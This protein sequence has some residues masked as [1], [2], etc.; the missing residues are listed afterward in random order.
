MELRIR[1]YDEVSSERVSV[2]V[3]PGQ[4]LEIEL[5]AP[6]EGNQHALYNAALDADRK[7]TQ[8][9]RELKEAENETAM[10]AQL[11]ALAQRRIAVLETKMEDRYTT[12]ELDVATRTAAD[13]A[14]ASAHAEI[15]R[16]E[17]ELEQSRIY[18][19]AQHEIVKQTEDDANAERDRANAERDRADRLATELDR[20]RRA[21]VCTT[22]CKPN[23]HTAFVGRRLVAEL[24]AMLAESRELVNAK[25]GVIEGLQDRFATL[26]GGVGRFTVAQLNEATR[27]AADQATA[28]ARAEIEELER[29]VK[30]YDMDRHAERDRADRNGAHSSKLAEELE[31][32][33]RQSEA[34]IAARDRL[35]SNA[36][37]KI[38]TAQEI[39]R[40]PKIS[41]TCEEIITAKGATLADAI[42]DAL[43]ALD[44]AINILA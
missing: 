7:L 42:R 8:V 39:L 40:A 19:R 1:T 4:R 27:T 32:L 2:E 5:V 29:K 17:T 11:L 22:E 36:T 23:E 35:L 28:S 43:K 6:V 34:S 21:H 16:L 3:A 18:G 31:A 14:T 12:A 37:T 38:S 44:P 24:E 26:A 15:H 25:N 30:A 10:K 9:R 20:Y 41:K 13:Q 33:K